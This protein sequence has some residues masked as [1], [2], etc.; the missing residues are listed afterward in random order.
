[1]ANQ[2]VTWIGNADDADGSAT[3]NIGVDGAGKLIQ[4]KAGK[5]LELTEAQIKL[6]SGRHVLVMGDTSSTV[7]IRDTNTSSDFKCQLRG[8][9]VV[10][11]GH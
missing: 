10:P 2:I 3:L 11:I 7:T 5:S 4:L 6:I 9:I 8:K 1:M